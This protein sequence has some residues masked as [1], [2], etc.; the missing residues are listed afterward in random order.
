VVE[1]MFVVVLVVAADA[2]CCYIVGC[3]VHVV[4]FL[5]GDRTKRSLSLTSKVLVVL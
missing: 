4:L 2:V 5:S 1:A 3:V